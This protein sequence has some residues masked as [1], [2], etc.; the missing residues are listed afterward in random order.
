MREL[1]IY[2]RVRD[3]DAAA[4]RDAALTMQSRLRSSHPGLTARLLA[5]DEHDADLQT[6]MEIYALPGDAGGMGPRL[7]ALVATEAARWSGLVAGQRHVEAFFAVS[8]A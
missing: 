8:G 4:A 6:W 3:A 2:Y 7:E 5:R 1:F